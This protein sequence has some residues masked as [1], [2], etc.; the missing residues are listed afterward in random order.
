[1]ALSLAATGDNTIRRAPVFHDKLSGMETFF[2]SFPLAYLH[3]DDRIN[4]RSIGANI[5]GLI[6]E[7]AQKR[8][9]LHV[10]L[11]WWAPA[12]DGA[13]AGRNGRERPGRRGA[14]DR[15]GPRDSAGV[16]DSHD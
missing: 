14:Q 16:R 3:H 6:E 12:D 9:Q 2:V 8:P 10:G 15:E 4:P 11:A 5:R 7:F 13:G 1:L